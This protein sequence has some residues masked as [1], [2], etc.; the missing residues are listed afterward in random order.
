M[1]EGPLLLVLSACSDGSDRTRQ[2][3]PYTADELWMCKP[4]A[5]SN[6]CLEL[7]QTT[8]YVYSDTSHA[9]FEHSPAVDPEFDC[10]YVYPTVDLNEV[11]GNTEDLTD[12]TLALRPLYNQAARFTEVC[13]MYAP[14]YHQMTIGTYNVEEGYRTTEYYDIAFNDINDAFS[15]YLKE[16]GNRPFVLMGHSQGTQMLL[17]LLAQRFENDAKLRQRLIS[18]LAIGPHGRLIRPQ[19]AIVPDS[20]DNIPLCEQVTQ[21]GCIIT[22]DTLAAGGEDGRVADSRPCV[23][24]TLLGGNPGV[25]ENTIWP[26]VETLPLPDTIETP[27][28]GYPG[29]HTANCESDGY[30]AI[31]TMPN[32][33]TPP[34]TPQVAQLALGGGLQ[35]HLLDYT[36]TLGDLL[37]I[38][39]TQAENMP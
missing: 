30:L 15:Q 16:S 23:N 36:W 20:F 2:P 34:L 28:V 21:T 26:N 18:V 39:A 19:G 9:V 37:R 35:T 13:N 31:D 4:D 24:P 29:L 7:D 8:T 5:A 17:E 6:R 1:S 32:K 3:N 22:Y 11:P 14:L 25:L 38:V 12:D 33:A 10:F 27:W